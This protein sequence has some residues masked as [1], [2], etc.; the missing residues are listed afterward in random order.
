[1][2]QPSHD[3]RPFTATQATPRRFVSVGAVILLHIVVI[4]ALATGLAANMAAKIV[5]DVQVAVVQE[6]PPDTKLPPPPPPELIKPPPPFVPPPEINLQ[7]EAPTNNA[8]TVFTNVAT[9]PAPPKPEGITA[10]VLAAGAGNN[11]A[12]RYYPA[13]AV[14]LNHEGATL[15]TIHVDV[16]GKVDNVTV[17]DS[18]GH[19]ELDQ[20]AITC[21]QE[22]W[23]FKPAEQNGQPV[24]GTK[25]YRIVWK[26]TGG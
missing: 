7:N 9:P 13:Q 22:R 6:K 12:S 15:V 17:A 2:D 20:A 8:P 24:A 19:D 5:Q 1:M 25:Q 10:P 16:T 26:L 18:S 3:L 14:R 21:V 4:Y 23:H 11:C